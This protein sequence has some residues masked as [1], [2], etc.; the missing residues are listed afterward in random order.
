[1]CSENSG[2]LKRLFTWRLTLLDLTLK[3][4]SFG[5]YMETDWGGA[6]G[7]QGNSGSSGLGGG[8]GLAGSG[9]QSPEGL[10]K[11]Q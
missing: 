1:M 3:E 2:S 9:R 11:G 6:V 4:E 7:M 8:V 5:C 10:P